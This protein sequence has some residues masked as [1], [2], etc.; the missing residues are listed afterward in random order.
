[1]IAKIALKY[2]VWCLSYV[3]PK[4]KNLWIF[5]PKHFGENPYQGNTIAVLEYLISNKDSLNIEIA[6]LSEKGRYLDR[7][8]QSKFERYEKRGFSSLYYLLR[9]DLIFVDSLTFL[10]TGKFKLVQLWH[11]TGFK[12]INLLNKKYLSN[13][14]VKSQGRRSNSI[15]IVATSEEDRVRKNLAFDS[16]CSVITGSPR[17]DFLFNSASEDI[18]GLLTRMKLDKYERVITYAPTFREVSTKSPFD[19]SF[20]DELNEHLVRTNSAL[21]IKRHPS[22]TRLKVPSG[23]SNL[24]DI[25]QDIDDIQDLLLISDILISDYSGIV[26]DFSLLDRP[27]I[28][29]GYDY[30][31]YS[32]KCRSFYYNLEEILPGGFVKDRQGLIDL[33]FYH[34]WNND[35]EFNSSLVRFRK[36][37]HYYVDGH[38]TK[39]LVNSLIERS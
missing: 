19:D 27:I 3:V 1:M 6:C 5:Y 30:D 31:E 21:L 8:T 33:L 38:S 7:K 26:T 2:V 34:D 10:E 28:F 17:N 25:T 22:D 36:R 39:R 18:E 20:W 29:F 11:G 32:V 9:A 15:L 23:L 14:A 13:K 37:F 12:N 24:S 35:V 4:K 16:E